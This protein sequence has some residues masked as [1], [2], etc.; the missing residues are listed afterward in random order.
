MGSAVRRWALPLKSMT[1]L[2][3][4]VLLASACGGSDDSARDE[5]R[6]RSSAS[7]QELFSVVASSDLGVGKNRFL[8]GLLDENDAPV[9]SPRTTLRVGFLPPGSDTVETVT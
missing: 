8:M 3:A 4:V 5:P 6:A 1:L 2:L 7:D 9:R